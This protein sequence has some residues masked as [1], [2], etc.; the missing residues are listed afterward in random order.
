MAITIVKQPDN[1]TPTY[2]QMVIAAT[3]SNSGEKNFQYVADIY[4]R[5]D[6]QSRLKVP[7]TPE[8]YG[9]FDIHRHI[10]NEISF[11][12]DPNKTG[13][14]VATQSLAT[15]SVVFSEEWR[16]EWRFDDNYFVSGS[17]GFI[18][19]QQPPFVV[20][21]QIVIQQDEPYTVSAYNGLANIV[22]IFSVVSPAGWVIRT[23]KPYVQ[24][25]P[26]EPG[27]ISLSNFRTKIFPTNTVVG[28]KWAFN[29]VASYLEFIDW[30]DNDWGAVQIPN[31]NKSILTNVFDGYKVR[32]DSNMWLNVYSFENYA[33]Y[34]LRIVSNTG[35]FSYQNTFLPTTG[36]DQWRLMTI[37][38]GPQ[39]LGVTAS[40]N[41]VSGAFPIIDDNTTEYEVHIDGQTVVD[42]L[43]PITF[44]IDRK[45]SRYEKIQLVFLDKWG[46]F[47]PY[48]FT[49]VNKQTKS[50]KRTEYQ[51]IYGQYAPAA[52]AWNYK[53]YDRG[54]KNLDTI[55]TDEWKINSDWVD[56][57]TSDLLMVL[58]ESPEVYWFREDGV[59][60]AINITDSSVERK[61]TINNQVINY[62]LTFQLSNKNSVQ[63][64]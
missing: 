55:I 14:S 28:K 44:K 41:V 7:N 34:N 50:I 59:V 8:G 26:A 51:K 30:D 58:F 49:L 13:W 16:P 60:L 33:L 25:T 29:G 22:D 15:Y 61:Q 4:C 54:T 5:G 37:G 10:Q 57:K 18:G 35:T 9:V 12:F 32:T 19:T 43:K 2:N 42:T 46:S 20:G 6:F 3:S 40:W 31:A 1:L 36:N 11:D 53:S 63:N 23:D 52:N 27:T 24:N 38:V 39:Q 17:I 56:Q 48:T 62:T 21:D 45:C 64:G 47:I